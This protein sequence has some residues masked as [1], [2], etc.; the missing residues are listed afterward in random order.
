MKK[1]PYLERD[2]R[3]VHTPYDMDRR[4][5]LKRI[6]GGLIITFSLKDYGLLYGMEPPQR[7]EANLNAYLRIGGDGRISCLT[8]KIEMGQGVITSLAL[9]LADELDVDPGRIDMIMGDTDL[10]PWDAGTYGSMTTRFF[11]PLLRAAGAQARSILLQLAAEQLDIPMEQLTVND[12]VISSRENPRK[13]VSYA[14][15]TGGK[16]IVRELDHKPD[17]KKPSEFRYM[18]QP[19]LRR[20]ALEKV[21]GAAKYAGD[22]RLP[23]MLYARILRPPSHASKLVSVDTSE[24]EKIEGVEAVRDGDLVAVLHAQPDIAE[25]ALSK[26]KADFETPESTLNEKNIFEHL[27]NSAGDG[28]SVD[29]GGS[30]ETGRKLSRTIFEKEYLDGYKAHAPIENHTATAIM[31]GD[32][33]KVWASTQTP[34]RAKENLA[35]ILGMPQEKVHVMQIFVG[36]GFGGKTSNQQAGEAA[37]LAKLTGKPV[38]VAWTRQEEFFYDHFRPAAV[39]RITSGITGEG[40]ISLWDYEVMFAGERGSAQFYDIP[41]HKTVSSGGG[42]GGPS[43][44]PFYTG[45]WRAPANNTNTFARESQMDIMAAAAGEDPVEFR[46]RHLKNNEKMAGVL[47]AAAEKFGWNPA[48]SPSGRGYGV[49]CGMDAGT[50]V[51]HVAEVEVDIKSGHVQVK[52]VTCAQNMG[53]SINPQGA[54]IQVEGCIVM[55]MGYALAEDVRF[56]GGKVLT[57]NFDTYEF[58]HFSWTPEIDVVILDAQDDSP[59]GGGEPAI[60]CMGAVIANAIFDACGAR[61][62]QLPM[63]PDRVLA[64]IPG[65]TGHVKG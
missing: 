17:L 4:N 54:T 56:E 38:Q 3:D 55:G 20:D 59:Q 9:M 12:G 40:D 1:D 47:K 57:R 50:L 25:L 23:G 63:T 43:A 44:H 29:A 53:L 33:M 39:V 41:N 5:F 7:Q 19:V 62:Y 16:E 2:F 24:A 64:A 21:T 18:N 35:E 26:I 60:I 27:V 37:R 6:G 34:F 61:L 31:E 15:L 8:G 32:V 13:K 45:A 22:V 52:R 42:R 30:L 28:R 65:S 51:A 48:K 36:G 14:E 49:A 46:L 11:G 10:C 58:T